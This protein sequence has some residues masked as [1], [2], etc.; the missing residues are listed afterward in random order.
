MVRV[1][2]CTLALLPHPSPSPSGGL[3][4]GGREKDFHDVENFSPVDRTLLGALAPR[5]TFTIFRRAGKLRYHGKTSLSDVAKMHTVTWGPESS[6]ALP[7]RA[8]ESDPS[9]FDHHVECG[10][11]VVTRCARRCDWERLS[12]RR[13]FPSE[14]SLATIEEDA[15]LTI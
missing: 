13:Q 9:T 6:P 4:V 7:N 1:W 15:L 5:A 2:G 14:N 11:N 10:T 8:H 3:R 12:G